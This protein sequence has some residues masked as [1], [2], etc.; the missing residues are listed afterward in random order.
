MPRGK[1]TMGD[2]NFN[3]MGR[4]GQTVMAFINFMH[5][6]KTW[7]VGTGEV[8]GGRRKVGGEKM[9]MQGVR[10]APKRL[11]FK[12]Q[13][14]TIR[15]FLSC[16]LGPICDKGGSFAKGRIGN[17]GELGRD[18]PTGSTEQVRAVHGGPKVA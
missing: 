18:L 14:A 10:C 5:D 15:H 8:G 13:K 17:W 4:R 16:F 12:Q 3:A 2:I 9:G 7:N 6:R 1:K 11:C